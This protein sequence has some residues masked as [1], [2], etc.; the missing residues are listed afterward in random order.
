MIGPCMDQMNRL[1]LTPWT[2][3]EALVVTAIL[4]LVVG[5]MIWLAL[6]PPRE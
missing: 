2:T 5:V 1:P 4:A 3:V 6:E